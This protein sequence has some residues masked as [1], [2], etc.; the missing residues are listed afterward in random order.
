M[1]ATPNLN[2]TSISVTV[3]FICKLHLQIQ[4]N[5]RLGEGGNS[6]LATNPLQS[7]CLF[8]S[9]F[10]DFRDYPKPKTVDRNKL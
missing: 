3:G 6:S 2:S 9:K 8:T 7:D 5:A 10:V 1:C 4:R